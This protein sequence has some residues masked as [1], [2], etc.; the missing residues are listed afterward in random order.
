MRDN[1]GVVSVGIFLNATLRC[2]CGRE[3][4]TWRGRFEFL[5][6]LQA[7]V[8]VDRRYARRF[9]LSCGHGGGFHPL[10]LLVDGTLTLGRH[11]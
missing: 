9:S 6:C 5:L 7:R 2:C 1:F 8:C 3:T 11:Y 4:Q 10:R